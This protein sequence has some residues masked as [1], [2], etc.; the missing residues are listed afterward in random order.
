MRSGSLRLKT[1]IVV[2]VGGRWEVEVMVVLRVTDYNG[3][4][5][6]LAL[7]KSESFD[8]PSPYVPAPRSPVAALTGDF[9]VVFS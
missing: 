3:R 1:V 5:F 2:A 7:N 6:G 9:H 4:A 8:C